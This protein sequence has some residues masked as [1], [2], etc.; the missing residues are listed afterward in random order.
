MTSRMRYYR[1]SIATAGVA[2]MVVGAGCN[3]KQELLAPQNPAVILPDQVSSATGADALRKGVYARL[4]SMTASADGAWDDAGLLAD[5]W[6]SANTFSQHQE[7]DSRSLALNNGEVS[8]V[9]SAFQSARGAAYTAIAALNQYLQNPVY[10]SQMWFV[11]GYAELELGNAFCNGIPL[12]QTVGET[13]N[14][15][16]PYSNAEV[17]NIA[18]AHFDSAM[19]FVANA[20]DTASQNM[21]YALRVSKAR[22]LV[23]LAKFTEAA[24]LVAP[25]P[26]DWVWFHTYATTSGDNGLWNYNNSVKRFTVGDSF[27]TG[28]LIANAIPFASAKDPRVPVRG[29]TLNSSLG[30]GFDN[31]TNLVTQQI[32]P[33]RSD[34]LPF[35]AGWDARLIEAEAK[36]RADDYAGM[37]TIMNALRASP[38]QLGAITSP[39]MTP[40]AVPTTKD[41]AIN[42]YFRETA[43]WQFSRGTRLPNLRR[44]VRQYG[45]PQDQVFPN[46]QF[47]K[48]QTYQTDVNFPVTTS[49]NANPQFKGCID[50]NA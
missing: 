30:L 18:I 10:L 7:L 41:A 33:N 36:L 15:S 22:A 26:T 12:G 43:F 17:F 27:D 21:Q 38:H 19:A 39:V 32:W 6:K 37:M 4:R 42:L 31:T 3:V 35:I 20:S 40:L 25:V 14:Y 48:G 2:T 46:G 11:L 50:R 24:A 8:S 1:R 49:E 44:L 16:K 9:Y 5:E 34:P 45:R 47:F 29:S 23:Q 13:A 28:G